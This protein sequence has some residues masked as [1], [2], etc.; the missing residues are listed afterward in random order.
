MPT[1]LATASDTAAVIVAAVSVAAFVLL[2]WAIAQLSRTLAA[3]R[4]TIEDLHRE[5]MPVV[6]ELQTVV[7]QTT[8]E[9]ERVDV[10]LDSAESISATVD[11]ASRLLY[12]TFSNPVI[13]A[14]AFASGTTRAARR[15]RR[16]TGD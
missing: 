16:T 4:T 14:L 9:L 15:F 10:V 6:T 5:T 11:S 12:L 8:A 3:L 13:K 7:R 1:V 2:V